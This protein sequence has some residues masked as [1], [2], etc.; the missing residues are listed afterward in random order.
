MERGAK[1]EKE[2][3]G[4]LHEK[5]R[6]IALPAVVKTVLKIL[7]PERTGE[8]HHTHV[9]AASGR[10]ARDLTDTRLHVAVRHAEVG[11]I[12]GVLRVSLQR[13]AQAFGNPEGLRQREILLDEARS[14]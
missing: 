7:E 14:E 8:L 6:Q 1:S 5:G 10:E 2:N 13:K 12:E 3:E 11:V 4:S 9:V